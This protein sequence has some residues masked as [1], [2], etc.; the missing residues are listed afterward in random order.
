MK[1]F[2]VYDIKSQTYMPPFCVRAEGEAV[3]GFSDQAND[4][5]SAIGLHPTDYILYALGDY[6]DRTG[7]LE[8][9]G[10]KRQVAVASDYVSQQ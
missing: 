4:K 3:R 6:D 5:N 2:T 10:E 1:V 7:V 8:L 9:L